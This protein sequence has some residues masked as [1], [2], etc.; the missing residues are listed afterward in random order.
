MP[1]PEIS[2]HMYI[3][4]FP[5]PI[6]C[7]IR[8]QSQR[9][10]VSP[11]LIRCI[12]WLVLCLSALGHF[13]AAA[14]QALADRVPHC[15]AAEPRTLLASIG[16]V[17]PRG[18]TPDGKQ[19]LRL[20]VAVLDDPEPVCAD[21]SERRLLLSWYAAPPVAVGEHWRLRV[22]ARPPW[23]FQNPGGF[24]RERWFLAEGLD[25]AGTVQGGERL[26]PASAGVRERLR[27]FIGERL[28]PLDHAA[29]LRALA[30]G[31]AAG[32]SPEDWL[33]LRRTGTVH[34]LVVSG[35]HV[36]LVAALAFAVGRGL[37]RTLPPLL[38]RWPAAWFGVV[39]ALTSV[40]AYVW[41]VGAAVSALRAGVMSALGLIAL[42]SGRRVSPF[43]WLGLAAWMVVAL[44]PLSL[45]SVGFWLSFGA[46][47]VLVTGF[48]GRW[49]RPGMV[50]GLVRAQCLML[51]AMSPLLALTLGEVAPSAGLANLLAVPLVS[52]CVVPPII[53]ALVSSLLHLPWADSLWRLADFNIWLLLAWLDAI[54]AFDPWP[55]PVSL[56]RG[57]LALAAVAGL[58]LAPDWRFR[59][60]CL[61]LW[62]VG[63]LP[64][65]ARPA[66]ATLQVTVLDVGQGDAILVDTRHHRLLFDAGPRYA[67]GF[68]IG[69]AVV[70]PALAGTGGLRLHRLILSHGD[71]DHAGGVPALLQRLPDAAL[72]TNVPGFADH[73]SRRPCYRGQSWTWDGIEFRVLHPPRGGYGL[74][75]ESSC[76]LLIEAG[77][78]RVLLTGDIGR[79]TER[80]LVRTGLPTVSL[81]VAP[82]HGSNTSS[83]PTFLAALQPRQVV[84]SAGLGNRY[85]HPH[86]EVLHRYRAQGARVW[87]TGE[88]GALIWQSS[89]PDQM[90]SWR[91]EVSSGWRFWVNT[92]PESVTWTEDRL[93]YD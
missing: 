36:G 45:L 84:F 58:L 89:A 7:L 90:R 6:A 47:A 23:G 48:A 76:V 29:W 39:V 66:D 2:K 35:L 77:A 86:P 56:A 62:G 81:L 14:T 60:A 52:A 8:R 30:I 71:L 4:P 65:G 17:E 93:Y 1:T 40:V 10:S 27:A 83:S 50:A 57:L 63:L 46:V 87:I 21:L 51:I 44:H 33:R 91:R 41:L 37:A 74:G 53:A 9:L 64:P 24:D 80:L 3:M 20:D 70:L 16:G 5:W 55:A 38:R 61:P 72:H 32:L 18:W 11:P 78:E 42:V 75:N 31:D 73:E 12:V 49:P 85:G 34:L 22:R 15:V 13:V 67:S 88:T 59:L 28:A 68:D 92:L 69:Q 26:A 43:T 25:G 82:H 54:V 79:A 19:L